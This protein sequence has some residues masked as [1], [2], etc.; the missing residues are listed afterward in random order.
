M[1]KVD[2]VDP[3][4]ENLPQ[5][6]SIQSIPQ[7]SRTGK[8]VL[9]CPVS[10]EKITFYKLNKD[11]TVKW[12]NTKRGPNKTRVLPSWAYLAFTN[13]RG[14][15]KVQEGYFSFLTQVKDS[16]TNSTPRSQKR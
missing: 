7:N 6:N 9:T 2:P 12:V 15:E 11:G 10:N 13:S 14:D 5:V 8:L 1:C 3:G 4:Q 16:R